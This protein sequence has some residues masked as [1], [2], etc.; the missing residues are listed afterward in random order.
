M[1]AIKRNSG[2]AQWG[3]RR[4]KISGS[5]EPQSRRSHKTTGSKRHGQTSRRKKA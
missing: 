1:P 5:A 2:K 4:A 3:S